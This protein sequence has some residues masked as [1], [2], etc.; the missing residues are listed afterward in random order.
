MSFIDSSG[1]FSPKH[2]SFQSSYIPSSIEGLFCESFAE[3]AWYKFFQSVC[4]LSISGLLISSGGI[5]NILYIYGWH[6]RITRG[7]ES[8]SCH[9]RSFGKYYMEL[10][11]LENTESLTYHSSIGLWSI[12]LRYAVSTSLN[13]MLAGEWIKCSSCF[14]LSSSWSVSRRKWLH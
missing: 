5:Y 14:C 6:L 9:I 8:A 4:P 10:L 7:R 2:A 12:T 11:L 13:S 1:Q 3:N